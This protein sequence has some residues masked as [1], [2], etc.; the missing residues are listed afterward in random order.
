M[1]T[2]PKQL[3]VEERWTLFFD[4]LS[5]GVM[6]FT[7]ARRS[8]LSAG[9]LNYRRKMDPLQRAREDEAIEMYAEHVEQYIIDVA[10]GTQ[11]PDKDRLNAA[12]AWLKVRN[13]R[14][15]DAPKETNINVHH[16]LELKSGDDIK[17]LQ[18]TLLE[19]QSRLALPAGND[20]DIIDAEV[21]EDDDD[22]A[23]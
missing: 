12:Q 19:R 1:A 23:T 22:P 10:M 7:A 13:K 5:H 6:P 20:P 17:A 4:F 8:G 9:Q 16:T 21:I 3:P 2:T 15:W 18:A 14:V 11:K